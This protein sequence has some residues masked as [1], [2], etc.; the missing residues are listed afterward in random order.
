MMPLKSLN[1]WNEERRTGHARVGTPGP[2]HNGIACPKCGKELFDSDPTTTLASSPPQKNVH[3][4][5]GFV[6]YRLA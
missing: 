5:C 1:E 3:C 6:G 2:R 4:E